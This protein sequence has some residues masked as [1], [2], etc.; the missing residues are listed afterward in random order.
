MEAVAYLQTR[1]PASPEVAVVLGSGVHALEQ[2]EDAVSVPY[3]EIPGFPRATVA[4]HA[5]TLTFGRFR[6]RVL[7]VQRGR[8]HRYEGYSLAQVARP[9]ATLHVLGCREVILTNAA[10]GLN[11]LY[12]AGDLMLMEGHLNLQGVLGEPEMP[13]PRGVGMPTAF[14][15]DV[16]S[17]SW[18][19]VAREVARQEG[20]RLWE[21]VYAALLGPNYETAAEIRMLMR[22]GVDAVGMSTAPEAVFAH[23]QGM[24]VLGISCVTNVAF[25]PAAMA[26]TSHQEV[27]DVAAQASARIDRL[28]SGILGT[29]T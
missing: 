4:G 23:A 15:R 3:E 17:A 12:R 13:F 1:L 5:G 22:Y 11:P 25:S 9:L 6:G 21:G 29:S 28:I 18:R 19:D 16:Y 20:I 27:L 24:R 8:F 10:G 2:I 7:A 26:K 14:G